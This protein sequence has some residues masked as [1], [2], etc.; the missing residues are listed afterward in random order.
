MNKINNCLIINLDSR[1]D[2]WSKSLEFREK[3]KASNKNVFRISGIDL[4]K[5]T[6]NL[7]KFIISGRIDL[8][9]KGFR[10]DK[11]S[12]LGELG[13][14]LSHYDS[15]KYVVDNNLESCLIL[16]DGINI[17]RNDYENLS[18]NTNLDILFVNK[19]ME[20]FKPDPTKIS[21]F[22]LQSYILTL[23]GA[24]KLLEVCYKLVLPID[25]QLRNFCNSN[26]LNGDVIDNPFA[27]RNNTRISSIENKVSETNDLNE[28][29]NLNH[30][31]FE[32]III[33]L[34]SKNINIDD[35]I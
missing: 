19:E 4:K 7:N 34:I 22:G 16:E 18:I 6:H 12:L 30:N 1:E 5:Q 10:R 17:L 8:N 20:K 2:L 3:W 28:K 35:F 15:W 9:A 14:Y 13:C 26:I 29:Q 11:N 25:L 33:N 31:F 24:K 23:K 32:R 27:E 21:G